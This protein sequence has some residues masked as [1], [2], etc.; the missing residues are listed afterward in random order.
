MAAMGNTGGQ[1]FGGE[2]G[3]PSG[4]YGMVQATPWKPS[5]GSD[6]SLQHLSMLQ[7]LIQ[8]Q[9]ETIKSLHEEIQV[10]RKAIDSVASN[11]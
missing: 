9:K 10:L 6:P 11:V 8:Q 2:Q 1:V 4:D 3:I 7:A 5:G